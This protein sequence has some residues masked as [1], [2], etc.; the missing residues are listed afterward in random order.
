[1]TKI[2]S[3]IACAKKQRRHLYIATAL[4]TLIAAATLT[5][6][7]VQ[8]NHQQ[9]QRD[10]WVQDLS[11]Q[12]NQVKYYCE[13]RYVLGMRDE[14]PPIIR[15]HLM[16]RGLLDESTVAWVAINDDQKTSY[17]LEV[18]FWE[19][20]PETMTRVTKLDEKIDNGDLLTGSMTLTFTGFEVEIE[21][22][23]STASKKLTSDGWAQSSE[24]AI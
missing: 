19:M 15:F 20:T 22:P 16:E 11:A 3:P 10:A 7:T 2:I 17:R 6:I 21:G 18:Y 24:N 13:D 5:A 9:L 14:L 12:I 1:M 8:S 23:A 4:A